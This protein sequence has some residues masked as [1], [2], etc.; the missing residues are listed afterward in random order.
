[1]A[2]HSLGGD[3]SYLSSLVST[4]ASQALLFGS[5]AGGGLLSRPPALPVSI[6]G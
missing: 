3:S 4:A 6:R 2:A 5:L 1:L